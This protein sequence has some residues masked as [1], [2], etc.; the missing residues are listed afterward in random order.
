MADY[1]T[2]MYENEE[3]ALNTAYSW[4]VAEELIDVVKPRRLVQTVALNSIH[5]EAKAY[6]VVMPLAVVCESLAEKVVEIRSVKAVKYSELQRRMAEM[7]ADSP[8]LK[9]IPMK[10]E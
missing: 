2:K 7:E 5:S 8:F 6:L 4:L 9:D 10:E 1:Q 3:D